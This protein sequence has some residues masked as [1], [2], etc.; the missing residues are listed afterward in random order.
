MNRWPNVGERTASSPVAHPGLGAALPAQHNDVMSAA[1][2]LTWQ[3]AP[4][5]LTGLRAAIVPGGLW[6]DIRVVAETG[7]TSADALGDA[8]RGAPEGL[9]LA[10]EAQTAG[11]GRQGRIWRSLPGA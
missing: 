7:S 10:A 8:R 3:A 1:E 4:L 11:R 9:V 6:T 5:N 2:S